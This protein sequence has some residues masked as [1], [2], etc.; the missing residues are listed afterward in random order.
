MKKW[1]LHAILLIGCFYQSRAQDVMLQGWYWDYPKTGQGKWWVDTI[2][3]QARTLSAAG[4]NSIWLPPMSMAG[5]AG[6][7][8]GYDIYD[9]YNLGGTYGANTAFGNRI[10]IDK[11]MDS[12]VLY[13]LTPIADMIYNHRAN[14]KLEVNSA[15]E[16]WIENYNLAK[17]NN[18]ESCYPSDRFK[19]FLPIG[20]STGLGAGIYYL[21]IHSA[22][23]SVDY[24][25]K[26]YTVYVYT[27][28]KGWANLPD[29]QETANNG[30]GDCAQQNDNI[31]LGR[32][33]K[34][35][36]DAGGCGTDEFELN[37][38]TDDFL[39]PADT[40]FISIT[41]DD[42]NYSDH[43]IYGIWHTGTNS[44]VQS[45]V[46]YQTYTNF[47]ATPSG[48][49]DMNYMNFKPN[50]NPTCLCGDWDAMLF[51]N[52]LDQYYQATIDSFHV[53][54][55]WMM[56]D[57]GV[58]GLRLDAV[59]NFTPEFTGNLLDYLHDNDNDPKI[60]VGES[61]DYDA[62][63]L[64]SRLDAVYSYMDEDTKNAMYYSLFDFNL[65]ASL[66]D[67]CD[68]FGYD[69][70]N[71]F[72]S[73]MHNSQQINRK[74]IISFVNNH[75]FREEP[76]SADNDPILGYAFILTNPLAG[77]PCVYWSD[78]HHNDYPTYTG[79][80]NKLISAHYHFIQ[81]AQDVDY[82]TRF[83]S[84]YAAG[85]FSGGASTSLIYQL[86]NMTGVCVP[87]RDVVVAINFSGSP[88]KVDIGVNTGSPYHLQTGD[89]LVDILG[90]SGFPYAIV[91]GSSQIYID[92][93]ARSYSV[94]ARVSPITQAPVVSAS[95]VTSFCNGGQVMLSAAVVNDC[96][97]YQW[98]RNSEI[99]QGATGGT[100]M[101]MVSGVYQLEESYNGAMA[102]LSNS[103]TVT[104][105]PEHPEITSDG[106][107]LHCTVSD[108][109]YQW[110]FGTSVGALANI[111]GATSQQH[112]PQLSGV[113]AVA[114]TDNLNC[115]DTAGVFSFWMV[116]I[117]DQL[118]DN[119]VS[120]F[121]N[122]AHEKIGYQLQ[123]TGC[124]LIEMYDMMG[125]LIATAALTN[126][127]PGSLQFL[128]LQH[129][130]AGAYYL[131]FYFEE[132]V[133]VKQFEKY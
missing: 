131:K 62:A 9:L 53:W 28:K 16:G 32:N 12:L 126:Y 11:M 82:L 59:K 75:D 51:Y 13:N 115:K 47:T 66:R 37:V 24:F 69:A 45:Q 64:K 133:I 3:Q 79:E 26:P 98:K 88:L 55:K 8:N 117:P 86:S 109:V 114:I 31:S 113:Y 14:G 50:G 96:H 123:T 70:R 52:D 87:G 46:R 122:P 125:K 81:G 112:T 65:Q 74:N 76:Q 1:I 21:K 18:G 129:F 103:I 6:F 101:V 124:K 39:S 104:V 110:M 19:C 5:N 107:A 54:T 105:S 80:I 44:D 34:A 10:R 29:L 27:K 49:G 128:D 78:Y 67:A 7:S 41:N 33:M 73:G 71:V 30:G 132:G 57:V 4:F 91:N 20:G 72:S 120:V 48:R 108:V 102:H 83:N 23:G 85:Y 56:E 93:P 130:S 106:V 2:A 60:I 84:P 77:I 43:F 63:T 89:T 42:S 40:L 36:I 121:P 68:A 94:W 127:V 38:T 99:I 61:Y 58:E 25:N 90:R 100:L 92:L 95:G 119:T 35:T 15:V 17:H 118:R 22:S 116:G 111:P 97:S